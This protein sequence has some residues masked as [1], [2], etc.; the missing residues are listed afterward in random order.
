[1]RFACPLVTLDAEQ[2]ERVGEVLKV[3]TPGEELEISL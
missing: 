2:R 1:M 3:Y